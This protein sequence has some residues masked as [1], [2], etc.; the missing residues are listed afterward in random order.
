MGILRDAMD[1]DADFTRVLVFWSAEGARGSIWKL[2]GSVVVFEVTK[3]SPRYYEDG[4]CT[5]KG[6]A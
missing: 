6:I 1:V 5:V 2:T 3:R 4:I